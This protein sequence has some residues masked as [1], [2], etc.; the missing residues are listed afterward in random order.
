MIEVDTAS[1]AGASE[2]LTQINSFADARINQAV[3][4][5]LQ[6]S[7]MAK[8]DQNAAELEQKIQAVDPRLNIFVCLSLRLDHAKALKVP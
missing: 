5:L 8:A 4:L 1:A 7:S 3:N 2:N 6:T